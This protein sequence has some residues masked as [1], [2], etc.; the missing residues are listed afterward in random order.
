MIYVEIQL[1]A[2]LKPNQMKEIEEKHI[3]RYY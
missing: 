2:S 1:P 3:Y